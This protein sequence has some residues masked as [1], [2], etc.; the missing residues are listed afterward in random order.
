MNWNVKNLYCVLDQ[1][2]IGSL[3]GGHFCYPYNLIHSIENLSIGLLAKPVE[4][5]YIQLK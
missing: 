4:A 1:I 2:H 3:W 5:T